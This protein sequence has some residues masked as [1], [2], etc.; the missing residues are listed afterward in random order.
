[1]S[2]SDEGLAE[3]KTSSGKGS[4]T[5]GQQGQ[6]GGHGKFHG[7][8]AEGTIFMAISRVETYKSRYVSSCPMSQG[9]S[10]YMCTFYTMWYFSYAKH[11]IFYIE[12]CCYLLS[13]K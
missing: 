8:L 13:V 12:S 1:M 10:S 3:N 5:E 4:S 6:Q 2:A 9:Y 7:Y 11:C